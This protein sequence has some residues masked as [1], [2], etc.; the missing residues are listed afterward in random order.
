MIVTKRLASPRLIALLVPVALLA[1]ADRAAA[2]IPIAGRV[3]LPD[4]RPAP[5]VEVLLV[6]QTSSYELGR[7]LVDGRRLPDPAARALTDA[8]GGFELEAPEA[9][10]WLL[11]V[12][13]DGYRPMELRFLPLLGERSVPPLELVAERPVEVK[14]SDAAGRPL[15]GAH[16]RT[17]EPPASRRRFG[18]AQG[19]AAA[20][21]QAVTDES[22]RAVL[23]RGADEALEIFAFADGHLEAERTGVTASSVS[24]RLGAATARPV[25]LEDLQGRPVPGALVQI[26]ERRWPVGVT[27]GDGRVE[28]P[29][30]ASG[31]SLLWA[32]GDR[33]ERGEERLTTPLLEADGIPVMT[34]KPPRPVSVRVLEAGS[35]EPLA[36][37]FVWIRGHPAEAER[38]DAAGSATLFEP[39]SATRTRVRAAATG[40]LPDDAEVEHGSGTAP[41]GQPE[42]VTVMLEIAVRATGVVV[43]ESGDPLE[44][45]DVEPRL[46]LGAGSIRNAWRASTTLDRTVSDAEGRFALGGLHPDVSYRLRATKAGFAPSEIELV[47]PTA[48]TAG[49]LTIVLELGRIATGT[50]A[51]SAGEPV[52]GARVALRESPPGGPMQRYYRSLAFEE[53]EPIEV[54]ADSEGRFVFRDLTAGLFDLEASAPGYAPTEVPRLEIGAAPG[55]TEIGEVT[56]EPGA[57]IEGRVS[58]SGGSAVA[59]AQILARPADVSRQMFV[60]SRSGDREGEPVAVSAG[61]G[62]FRIPDRRAGERLD[63]TVEKP[64]YARAAVAG[65][66]APT[67]R[68]VEVELL[69]ASRVHGE[70]VDSN[71]RPIDDARVWVS[72]SFQGGS[73]TGDSVTT[74]ERGVFEL[75]EVAPGELELGARAEGYQQTLLGSLLVEP[76]RDLE[77]VRIVLEPGGTLAGRITDASGRGVADATVLLSEGTGLRFSGTFRGGDRSDAEGRYRLEGLRPGRAELSVRHEDFAVARQ[78]VVVEP[79]E[80]RLDVTLDSGVTVSGRVVAESGEPLVGADVRLRTSSL[81]AFGR[82]GDTSGSDGAF[83]IRGVREGSYTLIAEKQGFASGVVEELE[84]GAGGVEGLEVRLAPGS[85]IVG[86]LIGLDPSEYASVQVLAG[87]RAGVARL[88]SVDRDG[89]Y[90]IEDLAPGSYQVNAQA[91]SRSARDSVDVVEGAGEILLD[92]EFSAGLTLTGVVLRRGEPLRGVTISAMGTGIAS[93]GTGT[94]DSEGRFELEGLQPGHHVLTVGETLSG[95]S[96]REELELAGDRDVVVRVES[97]RVAGTV[98]DATDLTPIS[99]ASVRLEPLE[100]RPELMGMSVQASATTDSAGS[101]HFSQ[102]SAGSYRVVAQ[103]DGY[104][105]G[106]TPITVIDGLDQEAVEIRLEPTE[107]LR[108]IVRLPS[109]QPAGDVFAAVVDAAGRPLI[110]GIYSSGPEGFVLS[111]GPGSWEVLVAASGTAVSSVPVTVPAE[112]LRVVLEEQALLE[113]RI[114]EIEGESVR[115]TARITAPDGHPFRSVMWMWTRSEWPVSGGKATIT[116]LAPGTW[117]VRV[118]AAD[119]RVWESQAIL[120]P[121]DN[122][123]L[124][125][126]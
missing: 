41:D 77:D 58:D 26:G 123:E 29:L 18:G 38:S 42:E 68:P 69:R 97:A 34:L 22:G 110:N 37:A 54:F 10:M 19:W 23:G 94:T 74:D 121:G 105:P 71:G 80:N 107:G 116:G 109:G 73:R 79:G 5:A 87:A 46:D 31:E 126:Q 76:E 20:R 32:L 119:G 63:L 62:S 85:A 12:A 3:E 49:G 78:T 95:V 81:T 1:G 51:G 111:V 88:G 112:P 114:P 101:F 11:R 86:R 6:A 90:R 61:D 108:V 117:L 36:A 66:E 43:D 17:S 67:R 30:P 118:E 52:A 84:V 47:E 72:Q 9:G 125:L 57:V 4:G 91:G 103:R 56:L 28:V 75:D 93:V 92:L 7:L 16:V 24:L 25:R 122:P 106:E 104:A 64:G 96:H 82:Q 59:G 89:N 14:I 83:S 60:I 21:R 99:G 98:L 115:A 40:H 48:E 102:A 44:G 55:E 27:D 45:V 124:V 53:D 70:V 8:E 113:I 13:E 39:A 120:A 65:V 50:V 35:R 15:P 33:G 2:A 100:D